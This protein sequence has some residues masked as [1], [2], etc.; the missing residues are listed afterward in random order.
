[1]QHFRHIMLYYFKKGK[2][3]T[4]MQKKICAVYGESAVADWMRM[5]KVLWLT[6]CVKSGSLSFVLEISRWTMLHAPVDQLKLTAINWD[7]ENQH[8]TTWEI[9]NILKMSKSIKLSVKMKNVSFILQIK[10]YRLFGQPSISHNF[11]SVYMAFFLG[12]VIIKLPF[13]RKQLWVLHLEL[14]IKAKKDSTLANTQLCSACT[15]PPLSK[16]SS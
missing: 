6:E 8:Y 10:P 14:F 4:E 9:A 12:V 16:A 3:A 7:I 15:H 13:K 2:N 1:M 11:L 5:E